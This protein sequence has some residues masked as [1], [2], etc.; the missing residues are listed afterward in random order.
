M[1]STRKCTL[2]YFTA[3][4]VECAVWTWIKSILISP[5]R[6][7]EGLNQYQDQQAQTT[8]PL[9][10]RLK[11]VDDLLAE[12]QTQLQRLIDLYLKGDFPQEMLTERKSRLET[13]IKNLKEEQAKLS[14][15][16][17]A[18]VLTEEQIR[19]VKDFAEKVKEGLA[20]A[21]DNFESRRELIEMLDIQVRLT[22]EENKKIA[23]VQCRLGEKRLLIMS[24]ATYEKFWYNGLR[25]I[26]LFISAV[27]VPMT[28][29]RV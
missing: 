4:E 20:A 6:L 17:E 29:Y 14:A 25:L 28:A 1:N 16:L 26:P 11:I 3:Y 23:Y 24:L 19:T 27:F 12:N 2:P 7:A 8:V 9:Q 15:H 21:D 18:K 10:E 13:T 5:E 22:I